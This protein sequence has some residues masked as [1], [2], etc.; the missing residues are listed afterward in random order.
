MSADL[1]RQPPMTRPLL[2]LPLL[3][4]AAAAPLPAHITLQPATT[5]ILFRAYALGLLPV[6]GAFTRFTGTLTLDDAPARDCR[7]AVR[8]EVASLRMDDANIRADVLSAN[9]LD[10]ARFPELAFDGSCRADTI[11]GTLALH[12][13]TRPV[14]LAVTRRNGEVEAQA[15]LRRSDWGITGRPV[16]AGRTVRLRVAVRL[17]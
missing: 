11:V 10:A 12:G 7:I 8:V 16:L 17:P 4:L 6:D 9:L 2:L 15:T 3:L 1:E 13:V 14:T 5:R